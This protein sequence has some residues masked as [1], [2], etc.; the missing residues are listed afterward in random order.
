MRDE[1]LLLSARFRG[2]TH[3]RLVALP[4]IFCR[5]N[6]CACFFSRWGGSTSDQRDDVLHITFLWTR[7]CMDIDVCLV[8]ALQML[9]VVSFVSQWPLSQK[10]SRVTE[11]DLQPFA[12]DFATSTIRLRAP[13]QPRKGCHSR[14]HHQR[15]E[16]RPSCVVC[17]TLSDQRRRFGYV[18]P[19]CGLR[20]EDGR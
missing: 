10:S 17:N 9:G 20:E 4:F 7:S 15:L 19:A 1:H 6:R 3:C 8:A 16:Q 12:L 2:L 5:L 13:V 11:I 14:G 18:F